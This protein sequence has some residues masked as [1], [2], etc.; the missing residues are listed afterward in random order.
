MTDEIIN[1]YELDLKQ[2]FPAEME[3]IKS[4]NESLKNSNHYF[5]NV[6]F[7]KVQELE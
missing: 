2:D 6:L 3:M 7:I 1:C 4:S 5:K